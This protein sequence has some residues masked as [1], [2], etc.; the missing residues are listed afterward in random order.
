MRKRDDELLWGRVD[1]SAEMGREQARFYIEAGLTPREALAKLHED[2]EPA[3][4]PDWNDVAGAYAD[5]WIALQ[6]AK[7]KRAWDPP[8][9]SRRAAPDSQR[10]GAGAALVHQQASLSIR[11]K[12]RK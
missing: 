7:A 9:V 1:R 2:G 5:C 4:A 3:Q 8:A 12:V 6:R 10:K 11:G